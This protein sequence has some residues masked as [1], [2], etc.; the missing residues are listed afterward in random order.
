VSSAD[1]G[2][3]CDSGVA[4]FELVSLCIKGVLVIICA[5]GVS[6]TPCSCGVLLFL[7][8]MDEL[9]VLCGERFPW[10]GDVGGKD[11]GDGG[12]S[13]LFSSINVC[14]IL[15]GKSLDFSSRFSLWRDRFF[16]WI[17]LLISLSLSFS[18]KNFIFST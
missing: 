11:N 1:S 16:S 12:S 9:V 17:S 2:G 15:L 6:V 8:T 10:T 3:C 13:I 14:S 18:S 5:D 4:G 7:C